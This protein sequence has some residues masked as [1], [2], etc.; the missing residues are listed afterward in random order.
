MPNSPGRDPIVTRILWLAGTEER[1]KNAFRRFIYI[2]GTTE[3]KRVGEPV[4]YGCIRMRSEDVVELFD[5]VGIG[6]AVCVVDLS[7]AKS[8]KMLR[9]GEDFFE[10][11]AET[12]P[13]HV[14]A[15]AQPEE[16][17]PTEVA[18]ARHDAT[19]G[20][21]QATKMQSTGTAEAI[22]GE[23]SETPGKW[24]T[25][26]RIDV[27]E[28]SPAPTE[29]GKVEVRRAVAVDDRPLGLPPWDD[30]AKA[31]L[32]RRFFNTIRSLSPVGQRSGKDRPPSPESNDVEAIRVGPAPEEIL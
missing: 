21:V 15:N 32:A 17:P 6:T 27:S 9:R 24:T 26:A 29:E 25:R 16:T 23:R 19:T 20:E 5:R 4:S 13:E 2:H 7:L 3:E 28:M 22:A 30:G 14:A 18:H 10:E 11:D 31:P 12:A 8:V 1:N